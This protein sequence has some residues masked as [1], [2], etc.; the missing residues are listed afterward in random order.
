MSNALLSDVQAR[1]EALRR[2]TSDQQWQDLARSA[3]DRSRAAASGGN[4]AQ[5]LRWLQRAHRLLP[6]D[7]MVALALAGALMQAGNPS[8]A[9]GLFETLGRRHALSEAWAGLATCAR[10]L[11]DTDRSVLAAAVA[12]RT[13]VPTPTLQALAAAVARTAG[14]P[15]WCGLDGDGQV[16]VGMARNVQL[17]LDGVPVRPAWSGGKARLPAGWRAAGVLDVDCDGTPCLGSPLSIAAIIAVEGIVEARECGL[18]GWAWHPADPERDPVLTI[19]GR[20]VTATAPAADVAS[21]R[22]L[23][24]PRHFT[25]PAE[26]IAR[27]GAVSVLTPAGRHLTGSPI[28]P[29]MEARTAAALARAVQRPT[30]APPHASILADAAMP[31]TARLA[32]RPRP[33]DVVVP[34]YRNRAQTLACLHS[35]LATVPRGTRVWVID[36]ASP[37][38][39]LVAALE[40][41]ARGKRIRLVRLPENRGFPATAN[42]G[43]RACAPRDAV[44]L[45]SDTL[46]P[47]GWLDRLRA[48]AYAAPDIGTV[49]PLSNDA[50]ILS[51]PDPDGGNPVPDLA[52]TV[53]TDALAQQANA[54]AVADIPTG[55][56]FCLYL[57][58]DCLEETGLFREDC[59]A[60][61]YGEE[62]DLCLRAR[63]LGWRSVAAVGVFVA[64]VGGQSFGAARTHLMR[65]N[66]VVLNRLHP[67]YDALIAA[68]VAAD[69]LAPAR[70]RID[71]LRWAAGRSRA[72]AVILMTHG[73]GGGVDRVVAERGAAH[74]AAGLRPI[75]LRPGAPGRNTCRIEAADAPYPNLTYAV[76]GELPE[77]A[78]LL[79]PDR[80]RHL[81]LHHLLGH[82][83]AVLGLGR[84][85]R[86][87]ADLFVHDYAWFC[88]RIALVGTGRRYCGE[89]DVAGCEACVADLGSMLHEDITVPALLARSAAN[90]KSARQIIAPS[91]DA[92]ARIRRH[93]PGVAP[94]VRN[95]E[96]DAAPP[97][98]PM[99]SGP[100]R[101]VCV[102]GAIGLEKGYEV[103]LA[104]VRDARARSLP[105]EFVVVGYTADDLRMLDAGPVFIT[106]EYAEAGAAALI[107]EQAAHLAFLPSVWPETWCF[108]LSRAWEAGL[109]VAAFDLGAQAERIRRTGRGWL[110]PL[111]LPARSLND[112]LLA[113]Q[114]HAPQRVSR[115]GT[116]QPRLAPFSASPLSS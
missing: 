52:A 29:A 84:L 36:D 75:V 20:A 6:N 73:G 85:L 42:A 57:R 66:L 1:A 81:E 111:G 103:L 97:T 31:R 113:L 88:P 26:A 5:A 100:V 61:G 47:P 115:P 101:R 95:W 24:R 59:F 62:N 69:P 15:G 102:V 46:V 27:D 19:G 9:A 104:C 11:G 39:D 54:D 56:G 79:R 65:R 112:A 80:P 110:L 114:P 37:E 17:R 68:H 32:A 94:V 72:G 106:G 107:R 34:A 51:Y 78:Q 109:A 4:A 89:P 10:L 45:N 30:A 16:H 7:G 25:L 63:H 87:P 38:P 64:H 3:W 91:E 58:R 41:L 82:D 67:G 99:P 28:D 55:V 40:A 8:R 53:A 116:L 22:P 50:T 21:D 105:I 13:S 44:L 93:F 14:L 60:Q 33:V 92:A 48:A 96:D 23:A 98:A 2:Q 77:L 43:L 49:T 108:A 35:V 18:Q 71:T 76:P 90:L 83:H 86:L 70:R 74:A 12:L